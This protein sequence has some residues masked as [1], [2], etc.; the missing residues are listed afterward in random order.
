MSSK[1]WEVQ[2]TID[3]IHD[4]GDAVK[5]ADSAISEL[6]DFAYGP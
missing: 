2:S 3:V 1:V 6:M 5:R 4:I